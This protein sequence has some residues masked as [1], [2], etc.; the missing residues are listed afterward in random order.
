MRAQLVERRISSPLFDAEAWVRAW[1]QKC[2]DL[3]DSMSSASLEKDAQ[4]LMGAADIMDAGAQVQ[5]VYFLISSVVRAS[6]LSGSEGIN[7]SLRPSILAEL[8]VDAL[9]VRGKSFVDMGAG[10]GR[11]LLAAHRLGAKAVTGFELPGNQGVYKTVFDA[12][13]QKGDFAVSLRGAINFQ[14][15]DALKAL[16]LGTETVLS[17]WVGMRASTQQRIVKLLVACETVQAV[18][19]FR[20]KSFSAP[21]S[22]PFG[23]TFAFVKSF[24]TH[25][26]GGG[27]MHQAWL[28]RRVDH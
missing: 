26:S 5:R 15:I 2:F 12:V 14:N 27:G 17:F 3:V 10:D 4:M 22:I 13:L 7:G 23:N 18:V 28:F 1:E 21:D 9:C 19:L 25:Q 8:L 24:S 11:V 16:P 6:A 20:C